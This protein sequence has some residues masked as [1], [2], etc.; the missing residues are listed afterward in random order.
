MNKRSIQ[1]RLSDTDIYDG[2]VTY[3]NPYILECEVKMDLVLCKV[4]H[5]KCQTG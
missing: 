2:V 4:Y 3:Q 5:A 1:E